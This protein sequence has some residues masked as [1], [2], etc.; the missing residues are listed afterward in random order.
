[1]GLLV[2]S[3]LY[4]LNAFQTC[5]GLYVYESITEQFFSEYIQITFKSRKYKRAD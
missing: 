5:K 3:K 4:I 2:F 1:M